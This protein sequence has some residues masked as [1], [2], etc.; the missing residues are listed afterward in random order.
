IA[1]QKAR[2][3]PSF[4]VCDQPGGGNSGKPPRAKI[5]T[6][7]PIKMADTIA[8]RRLRRRFAAARSAGGCVSFEVCS[9]GI[10]KPRGKL[11]GLADRGHGRRRPCPG[12]L[13]PD[14]RCF[15]PVLSE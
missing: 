15:T 12:S 1:A 6:K 14:R 9:V 8:A 7:A 4:S 3:Y 11:P 10:T 5:Q 13:L 2:K